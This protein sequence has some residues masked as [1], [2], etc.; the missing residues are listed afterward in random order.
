M[1]GKTEVQLIMGKKSII[2]E[3]YDM[4]NEITGSNI[5]YHPIDQAEKQRQYDREMRKLHPTNITIGELVGQEYK[6]KKRGW[7]HG[8]FRRN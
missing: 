8:L 1:A 3:K 5:K 2:Q 4:W 7:F 6:Q